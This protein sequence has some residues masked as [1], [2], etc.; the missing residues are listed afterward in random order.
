M[1]KV[2]VIDDDEMLLS[3]MQNILQGEGYTILS[4]ADGPRGIAIYKEERPDVVL[5]DL[6]LPSMNG[7]EVLRRIRSFDDKAK[8]IVV[9]G[10]GSAESVEV[11]YRSG[12]WDFVQKPFNNADVLKLIKTA[13]DA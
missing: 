1:S 8:V 9:T 7:L 4:T 13:I 10:Y 12:A 3:L 5:L 11:A 6:G 2:L